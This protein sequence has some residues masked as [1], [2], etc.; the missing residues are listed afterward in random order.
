MNPRIRKVRRDIER[1]ERKAAELAAELKRL[2]HEKSKLEDA[3]IARRVRAAAAEAGADI[4][5]VL[6]ELMP[7]ECGKYV[8]EALGPESEVDADEPDKQ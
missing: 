3:E 8:A 6:D 2:K 7:A 4:D 1:A 5:A